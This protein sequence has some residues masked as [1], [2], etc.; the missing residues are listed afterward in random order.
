MRRARLGGLEV[1]AVGYGCPTFSGIPSADYEANAIKVLHRTVERGITYIDTADH[2]EGNNEAIL[3]KAFR[4]RWREVQI[5]SKVGNRKSWPGQTRDVDG[6][7]ETIAKLC[8]ES[9]GRLGCGTLDLLY[10][11]RVDPQVPIEESV[12]A[13]KRLVEAG[14]VRHIGLSEAGAASLRRAAAVHPVAALQSEYSLWTREYEADSFPAAKALGIGIVAY[15]PLGRGFLSGATALGEKDVR[16]RLP[17]FQP[18]NYEKNLALLDRV[19]ALASAKGC[20]VG[21]LA[22]AWLIAQGAVPIAGTLNAQHLDENAA[23]GDIALTP[24]ELT[25]LDAI[26][27]RTGAVAGPRFAEDRSKEL[28]I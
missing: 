28:N 27:P 26:F 24:A 5:A 18:G 1:S 16:R 12:G 13:L 25:A 4:G 22:L 23:A 8:D 7:P 9:L 10:L 6:R 20:T 15:Y 21:Q 2:N 14:K 3:A 11:H 19:K 17:R